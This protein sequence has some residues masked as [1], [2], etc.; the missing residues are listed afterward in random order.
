MASFLR[1][2][3][4]LFDNIK[5]LCPSTHG[6][7]LLL[8]M[9]KMHFLLA[10]WPRSDRTF[11]TNFMHCPVVR[12][13]RVATSARIDW[14]LFILFSIVLLVRYPIRALTAL[15]EIVLGLCCGYS[16]LSLPWLLHVAFVSLNELMRDFFKY[17]LIIN[18]VH[19]PSY[20]DFAEIRSHF[21]RANVFLAFVR[22]LFFKCDFTSISFGH[23]RLLF[24]RNESCW[25]YFLEGWLIWRPVHGRILVFITWIKL[26]DPL[27]KLSEN[28]LR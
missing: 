21:L 23:L 27:W 14:F 11:S 2:C 24:L 18:V 17:H 6:L 22:I 25:F 15:V 10:I 16:F 5:F 7:Y 9:N 12:M 28:S 4:L 26:R 19:L 20:F 8:P 3:Q 13:V 1:L